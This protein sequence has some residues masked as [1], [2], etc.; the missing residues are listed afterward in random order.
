[1]SNDNALL[2]LIS[3]LK[4]YKVENLGS[5]DYAD[6]SDREPASV[7]EANVV[8][9]LRVD[10]G[11]VPNL[12]MAY[13]QPGDPNAI[14][15]ASTEPEHALLLDLDVPAYLVPSSTPGHSHLYIDVRIPQ[16]KYM[17]LLLAL[18]DAGVIEKGYQLA[19]ETRG[20]TALR[21]P[22]IKKDETKRK[23]A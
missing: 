5:G 20:A 14:M 16:S 6:V 13:G 9:S 22:W 7:V 1:M 19:S 18:A 15:V 8:S 10:K 3:N 23:A 4:T 2:R 11:E 12:V 17:A 21:L